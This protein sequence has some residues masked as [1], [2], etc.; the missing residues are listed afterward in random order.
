MDVLAQIPLWWHLFLVALTLVL[1]TI[2]S[3]HAIL[4]KRDSRAAVL[5]VSFIWLVPLG[6]AV[7][8]FIFGVNRI[9]R[10]AVELRGDLEHVHA[11]GQA[12]ACT[13]AELAGQLPPASRHLA[14]LAEIVN[15]IAVRPLLPGNRFTP[16]SDGDEAYPAMLEAIGAAKRSITLSTYIF[17][18]DDAGLA[19]AHALGEAV[20][21]GVE[22][23]V[24]IDATGTRY[25]WP[26]ILGTLRREKVRYARFLP[27]FPLWRL[28]SMNLRNHRK[29][30]VI[31]GQFGFTGGM[32]IRVGHWLGKNPKSPVCD[33][34]FRV[35][36][37]V[38]AQLQ[39]VFAEDWKFAAG[40][41]LSG[42]PWFTPLAPAG[43]VFAR[44]IADGPD[45]EL[46]GLRWTI[47]GALTIAKRSVRI[48]TPYFLPFPT[49]TS[50]LNV[51]AMRGVTVELLMPAKNNL[52][53]VHWASQAMWWQVLER[54]CRVWLAP[55]PFDHTKLMLVD[56]CWA[57]I[58]SANWDP[59]SLRLNFEL[60]VECYD[61]ELTRRLGEIFETKRKPAREITLKEVDSRSLPVRLRDGTARLLTPYL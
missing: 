14:E 42:E 11:S 46:D 44:G 47:L 12:S 8:Y 5:W 29:I 35:E 1:S 23:R 10:R 36:G 58:G 60:N 9:K 57:F 50:A 54:G 56:D 40:E 31:D 45:E 7:L 4:R 48:A 28:L 21:R 30:L 19:F 2:G 61:P 51:A 24:L 52:P 26:P 32:N 15:H 6:G 34:H 3:A 53:F 13:P 18:R 41:D 27:S 59:R 20:R 43:P 17:D 25:S 33:L 38:V 16:L 22:V 55:P 37:P 49:L 39:A